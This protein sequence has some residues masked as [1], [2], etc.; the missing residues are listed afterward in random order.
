MR[1]APTRPAATIVAP[2]PSAPA[3]GPVRAKESG[4]QPG[5]EQPVEARDAAE[6]PTRHELLQ[7]R[8]PDDLANFE[9]GRGRE[10]D[11]DRLPEVVHEP[12]SGEERDPAAPGRVHDRDP[13]PWQ[14]ELA[15]PDGGQDR[16]HAADRVDEA[17]R[18]GPEQ[19]PILDQVRQQ[20]LH[21]TDEGQEAEHGGHQRR[22]APGLGPN[23]GEALADLV[24]VWRR[25]W[26]TTARPGRVA[27]PAR[28]T[29]DTR[30]EAPSM[31][32][33]I[34]A[35]SRATTKPAIA[36]PARRTISGR[37]SPWS[38]LACGSSASGRRSGTMAVEAGLKKASPRPTKAIRTR[39]CHSSICRRARGCPAGRSP[40]PHQV[41]ADH[42]PAAVVAIA[43]DAA[44]QEEQ[45]ERD[46]PGN[47]HHRE[48]GRHVADLVD[49]P[50]QCDREEAVA[51]QRDDGPASMSSA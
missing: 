34:P 28:A 51:E 19:E 48:R 14:P 42:Q 5:R 47:P 36:G 1:T 46:R 11:E 41:G 20:H 6:Q 45:D 18:L 40:R 44:E 16:T 24:S 17:E 37:K 39:R 4:H 29:A 10:A 26:A 21:R 15:D 8:G 49:L 25:P 32:K 50:G 9:Q 35:P 31:R 22:P 12:V 23:E 13:S 2:G 43:E 30:N 38:A 7:Q 27:I 3:T 33:A